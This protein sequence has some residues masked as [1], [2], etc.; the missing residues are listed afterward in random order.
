MNKPESVLENEMRKILCDFEVQT[1]YPIPVRRLD[2]A[3][4][5]RKKRTHHLADD[6]MKMKERLKIEK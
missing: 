3:S 1:D 2:W 4:I 5:N 6:R